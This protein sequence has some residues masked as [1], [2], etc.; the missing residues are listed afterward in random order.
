MKRV[1]LCLCFC[2]IFI[3]FAEVVLAQSM[4]NYIKSAESVIFPVEEPV[5]RLQSPYIEIFACK[6]KGNVFDIVSIDTSGISMLTYDLSTKQFSSYTLTKKHKKNNQ[7]INAICADDRYLIIGS[8]WLNSRLQIYTRADLNSQF[9]L[10]RVLELPKQIGY[11]RQ[12]FLMP[13]DKVL[14]CSWYLCS[15][16]DKN[17]FI[18]V[19]LID[20]KTDNVDFVKSLSISYQGLTYFT[21]LRMFE[22][23]GNSIFFSEL[24][25]Y[26]I[27]E[28]DIDFNL[29]DSISPDCYSKIWK[30][31]PQK[32]MNKILSN[33]QDP[34]SRIW[35][36]GSYTQYYRMNNIYAI[37]EKELSVSYFLSGN[38][39]FT[40]IWRK[41]NG[42]WKLYRKALADVSLN[43]SDRDNRLYTIGWTNLLNGFDAKHGKIYRLDYRL[44]L[45]LKSMEQMTDEEVEK[46]NADYLSEHEKVLVLD[47]WDYN[48]D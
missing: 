29:K 1:G 17:D 31:Y 34:S 28:Y 26:K 7:S 47:L 33:Y 9:V 32:K 25:S 21:P 22:V 43:N 5:N 30:P 3:L 40:D 48:F 42:S 24:G 44:P 11:V 35:Y 39:M 8:S 38:D 20:L 37:S 23:S 46:F 14:V 18:K 12:I 36:L 2:S 45:D 15:Y 27:Y 13:N 6:E 10:S 4:R 19:A 16:C 41:E